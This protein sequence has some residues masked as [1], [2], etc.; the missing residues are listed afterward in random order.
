MKE[1]LCWRKRFKF[2]LIFVQFKKKSLRIEVKDVLY[3]LCFLARRYA[4]FKL[5]FLLDFHSTQNFIIDFSFW[6]C[7]KFHPPG[8]LA[9][10][11]VHFFI[12]TLYILIIRCSTQLFFFLLG[13]YFMYHFL[14]FHFRLY[15]VHIQ[16]HLFFLH[17]C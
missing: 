17:W 15:F 12:I 10:L 16:Q 1:H 5:F 14:Y 13:C 6:F 8:W 9:G 7:L 2:V 4:N 3:H 11:F